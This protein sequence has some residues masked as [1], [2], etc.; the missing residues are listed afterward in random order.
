MARIVQFVG[1]FD[2]GGTERQVL[3]LTRGLRAAG[4]ETHLACFRAEGGLAKEIGRLDVPV[5]EFP[6]SSLRHP[7]VLKPLADLARHLR[8]SRVDVVHAHGFYP[9][10]LAVLGARLAGIPVIVASVR[11]LGHMWT[12]A[13]RRLQRLVG[14][15]ADAVVA[16]ADAVAGRL[17]SEGWDMGRVEV[18]R[19]GVEHSP[20]SSSGADLRHELGLAPG[21]PLVGMVSRLTRLKGIEDFLGA[22]ALVAGRH[23]EARFPIVGGVVPDESHLGELAYDRELGRRAAGL[24]LADRVLFL[25][26]REDAGPILR[27]LTVS[28]LPSWSEGLSNTLIESLAAGVASVATDVGGNAEVVEDGVTGFLVPPSDPASLAAAIG[29]LL[30]RPDLAASF[31]AAGRRRY[32]RGFTVDRMVQQTIRLYRRLLEREPVGRFFGRVLPTGRGARR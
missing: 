7:R 3:N 17:R 21:T 6:I 5:S 25:G 24:G 31:G 28:V 22:A 32:E 12:P 8:R 30:E 18:I 1:S 11:D 15:L 16:N 2:I 14:S 29:R 9:N 23:P 13:Q 4:L 19:N 27:Q 26:W 20:S 10:V